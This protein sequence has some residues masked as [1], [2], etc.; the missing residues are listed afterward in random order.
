MGIEG[1]YL[2]IIKAIYDKPTADIIFNDEKM[3]VFPEISGKGK[4][5]HSHHFFQHSFESP[6]HSSQRSKRKKGIQIE[7][8]EVK[9][10]LLAHDMILY[11]ENP[12]DA[13]RK[14]KS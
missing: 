6:S 4:H 7:K 14:Y 2:K 5:I 9:L 12:K 8:Q 1:N 10:S 3:K 13:A 11:I